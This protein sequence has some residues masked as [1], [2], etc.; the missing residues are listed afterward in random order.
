[1]ATKQGIQDLINLNLA[2]ESD[3]TAFEH[4]QVETAILNFLVQEND[5][6]QQQITDIQNQ[7]APPSNAFIRKGTRII[8]NVPTD[9]FVIVNFTPIETANY[10]VVGSLVGLNQ[11]FN[12]D[13]DVFWNISQKTTSSFRLGLREISGENQNLVFDYAIILL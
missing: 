6:L 8:G 1:M 12:A 3:I 13:N 7:P 9:S 5:I 10:M 11:N 4:R 2:S